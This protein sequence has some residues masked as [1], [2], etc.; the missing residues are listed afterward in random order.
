CAPRALWNDSTFAAIERAGLDSAAEIAR[1]P[2]AR[3]R[4]G[5]GPPHS[6]PTPL[7]RPHGVRRVPA[8]RERKSRVSLRRGGE[9][10]SAPFWRLEK[11]L[12]SDPTGIECERAQPAARAPLVQSPLRA[13]DD[14]DRSATRG[15]RQ[16]AF[17]WPAALHGAP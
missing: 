2:P 1:A 15:L 3:D 10:F 17:A 9:N 14:R 8:R 16:A 5:R 12:R 13:K 11:N 6:F 7:R 4:N